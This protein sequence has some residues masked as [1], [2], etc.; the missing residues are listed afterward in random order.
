MA[1]RGAAWVGFG[2]LGAAVS[3]GC[4]PRRRRPNTATPAV[5]R[6]ILALLMRG[7]ILGF[8]LGLL[9]AQ[10]CLLDL[11]GAI[12][13]GDGYVDE[14][15]GEECDPALDSRFWLS[16]PMEGDGSCNRDT[17]ELECCGDMVV[18]NGEECDGA[19][20]GSIQEMP[21]IPPSCDQVEIPGLMD[22][23]FTSGTLGCTE[24]C[25]FDYG[26][27]S[28]CNNGQIDGAL[29]YADGS[30]LREAEKCDGD[31]FRLEEQWAACAPACG[32]PSDTPVGCNV[33]CNNCRQ[34]DVITPIQCCVPRGFS[35]N[36]YDGLGCCC[37]L[38][39]LGCDLPVTPDPLP[40]PPPPPSCPPP[41]DG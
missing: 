10:A 15:A 27:C 25:E 30:I 18:N 41:R 37:E 33:R 1:E 7:A 3:L 22:L 28:L 17:C 19:D 34:V 36:D 35:V 2:L 24:T 39:E 20:F 29:T 40:D 4:G 38:S 14:A 23:S 31:E 6:T 13:C 11:D 16:C 12:A 9:G 21:T 8:L 26:E 32:L 5:S